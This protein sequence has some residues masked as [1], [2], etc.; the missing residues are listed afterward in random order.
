MSKSVKLSRSDAATGTTKKSAITE[1]AGATNNHPGL[2][3]QERTSVPL[4]LV[5]QPAPL[6]EDR[7]D[8]PIER[9]KRRLRCRVAADRALGVVGDLVGDA[10]PLRDLR[11]RAHGVELRAE[12]A[13]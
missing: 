10:L 13:R 9:R 12:G 6:L 2:A 1:S 5:E 7:V 3:R 11:R 4:F 8:V